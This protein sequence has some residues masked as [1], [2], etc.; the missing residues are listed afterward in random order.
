[1]RIIR[2]MVS[3]TA[4]PN[5]RFSTPSIRFVIDAYNWHQTKLSQRHENASATN[6]TFPIERIQRND[7]MR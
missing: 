3:A 6:G 2:E 7:K 5:Y 1:M 4:E